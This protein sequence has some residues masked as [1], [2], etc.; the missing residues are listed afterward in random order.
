MNMIANIV[1]LGHIPSTFAGVA[2]LGLNTELNIVL[3]AAI[4]FIPEPSGTSASIYR[5]ATIRWYNCGTVTEKS[6]EMW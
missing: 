5:D 1:T 6:P 2:L 4:A 3:I